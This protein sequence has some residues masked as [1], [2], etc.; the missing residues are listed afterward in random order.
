MRHFLRRRSMLVGIL[1]ILFMTLRLFTSESEI[2]LS[3]DHM[4]YMEAADSF[5]NH[6]LYNHQV[7]LLHPPGYPYLIH[8]FSLVTG[9]LFTSAVLISLLASAATFFIV[10]NLFML[11]TGSFRISFLVLILFSLSDSLIIAGQVALREAYLIMLM[12]GSLY[13][14]LTALK[15]K[16]WK[17]NIIAALLGGVLAFSSDH[18]V[19][20]IPALVLAY[21]LFSPEKVDALKFKLPYLAW[22]IL[23]LAIIG[24][25]YGGWSVFKYDQYSQSDYYPNGYE[26]TPIRTD[27]L[28]VLQTISPQFFDDFHGSRFADSDFVATAKRLAFNAG[29]M[30]NLEPFAVPP[31]LNLSTMSFLLKPHHVIYMIVLYLP[32]AFLVVL[33][34]GRILKDTW[35]ERVWWNNEKLFLLGLF[36]LWAFPVTQQLA[37]PRYILASYIFVF[38]FIALGLITILEWK[39]RPS[40]ID[41]IVKAFAVSSII[42]IPAWLL[43]H[44]HFVLAAEPVL[45]ARPAAGFINAN[46]PHDAVIMAQPGYGVKLAFQTDNPVIGLHAVPSRLDEIIKRF[47]V[48][49][50]V[51]GKRFTYDMLQLSR[52]SVEYVREH[53]ERYRLI[54]N[55]SE[56]YSAFFTEDDPASSDE[57][58]IY[59]VLDPSTE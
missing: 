28:G 38:Y 32:L 37:S 12:L 6:L 48:S 40:L 26:G 41:S 19:L 31:G 23:P 33:G 42:L 3:S 50:V 4:K 8:L 17:L 10:Y 16:D 2:L 51:A 15:K 44:P 45:S 18:V 1:F 53:P 25:V 21:L 24:L 52:D 7:Y 34:M 13:F 54:A 30:L 27:D 39:G 29:Y 57:I 58:W 22:V 35:R 56:D 46:L 14:F 43:L 59:E 20:L 55:L 11:L 9:D 36:A 5:P 49:Y 47:D